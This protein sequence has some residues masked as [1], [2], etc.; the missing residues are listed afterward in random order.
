LI[1][2]IRTHCCDA[3][4]TKRGDVISYHEKGFAWGKR[5][6]SNPAWRIISVDITKEVAE[7]LLMAEPVDRKVNPYQQKRAI[8][9][10]IDSFPVSVKKEIERNADEVTIINKASFDAAFTTKQALIDP[11]IL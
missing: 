1:N 8:K 2:L 11:N 9:I 10:D 4:C 3:G 6:L 7:G 5:Q